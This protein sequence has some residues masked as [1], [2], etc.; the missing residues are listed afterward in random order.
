MD[1]VLLLPRLL[2]PVR[3]RLQVLEQMAVVLEG[4]T[5]KAVLPRSEAIATYQDAGR[6]EL[7]EHVLL[8]GFINMHT[9]SA[10]SLLRGYAD[11]L[12]LQ[13]WLNDHIW[14]IE[15]AFV[16]PDFVHDGTRLAIAEMLRGGTTFF[17]DLYFF[18][19]VT[20]AAAVE[21]GIR[22]CIGLP[23]IDVP[24][25]WAGDENDYIDKGLKVSESWQNEPL[26]NTAFS[27]HAPY[28][29]G[30]DALRRIAKM[31]TERDLRVHMHVLESV[32]E[33][34]ESI[35]Q[36]GKPTL[37]RLHD[38]GLLNE[39]LLA[40]HM[41]QLN[42]TDMTALVGA[43]VNVIHCP[44]SNLKLGNGICDV[45][46]LHEHGINLAL[47]TDSA[48]SNND[49]DLLAESRTAALLAKGHSAD[50]CVMNAF[51]ALEM[52]TI[53][54]AQA[55]GM[56]NQLGSIDAGTFA[57][58]CAIRLASL[59]STPMYDVVSHLIYTVSSQQVSHVWV[60]GRML[61]QDGGFL[62]LDVDEIIVRAKYWE[63]KIAAQ[64]RAARSKEY[65]LNE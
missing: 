36:H 9:H 43:D 38:V 58:L 56:S 26:L 44:E 45:G 48:A 35:R 65:S 40:V 15:K 13:V 32:W 18:P 62:H 1:T 60:G 47:G 33:V 5:I 22:A 55:L 23:V 51:Q 57:E 25:A 11:D 17:N 59:Y 31:S 16:G 50:P 46:Q 52:L 34:D 29:V 39:R 53:N 8:P 14:P 24:S 7:P 54:A 37:E 42:G 20:A 12:N 61:I 63:Q 41:T 4:E 10:M 30:D 21:A 19:E 64:A 2:V 28:S 49:L 6:I 27:P 3:P